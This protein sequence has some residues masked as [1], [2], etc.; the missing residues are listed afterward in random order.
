L[1]GDTFANSNAE[2]AKTAIP[3]DAADL[4]LIGQPGGSLLVRLAGGFEGVGV[5][6]ARGGVWNFASITGS[7][8]MCLPH[9]SVIPGVVAAW[10][11]TINMI[12]TAVKPDG[13]IDARNQARP[14]KPL[15]PAEAAE[16]VLKTRGVKK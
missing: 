14:T 11:E 6:Y 16:W 2:D 8:Y 5:V 1:W 13:V 4:P 15:P 3:L 12:V 10:E 9:D 7:P